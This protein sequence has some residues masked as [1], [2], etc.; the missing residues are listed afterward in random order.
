M[1][2]EHQSN[3]MSRNDAGMTEPEKLMLCIMGR[4]S[5]TDAPIVF[6]GALITKLI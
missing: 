6:K 3:D 5:D 1:S 4:I 2:N